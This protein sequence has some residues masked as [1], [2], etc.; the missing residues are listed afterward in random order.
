MSSIHQ[1][2]W[3]IVKPYMVSL[4]A[5]SINSCLALMALFLMLVVSWWVISFCEKTL[6]VD[7]YAVKVFAALSDILIIVHFVGHGLGL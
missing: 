3:S 6:K 1:E 5:D 2:I 7:P 4:I